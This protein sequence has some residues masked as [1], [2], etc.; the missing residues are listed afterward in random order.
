[1]SYEYSAQ[2]HDWDLTLRA[3][4]DLVTAGIHLDQKPGEGTRSMA[5]SHFTGGMVLSFAAVE[6]FSASV[7]RCS[8]DWVG[9]LED[10]YFSKRSLPMRVLTR[11]FPT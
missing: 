8:R 1:M 2:N 6:S 7:A 3:A 5:F 4:S 10:L 9:R 11:T